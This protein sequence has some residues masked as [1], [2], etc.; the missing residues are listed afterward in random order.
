MKNI[1]WFCI[2]D[3]VFERLII[4]YLFSII[5]KT[6]YLI[7]FDVFLFS[8]YVGHSFEIRNKRNEVN[9]SF[10]V[11][12]TK[13]PSRISLPFKGLD[14]SDPVN[15]NAK[16]CYDTPGSVNQEQVC[17]NYDNLVIYSTILVAKFLITNFLKF[18]SF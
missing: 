13:P 6:I 1:V 4:L 9:D 14:L 2:L 5:K 11:N 3:S 8:G 7:N 12:A 17:I 16:W 18:L 10:G 15:V